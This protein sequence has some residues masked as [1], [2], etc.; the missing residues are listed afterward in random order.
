MTAYLLEVHVGSAV[1]HCS[2]T[3]FV[4][5]RGQAVHVE[6]DAE[7]EVEANV[8]AG[9]V[10]V[11]PREGT[12]AWM[13]D[14]RLH[15][16]RWTAWPEG[17]EIRVPGAPPIRYAVRTSTASTHT[18]NALTLCPRCRGALVPQ[19]WTA[20]GSYRAAGAHVRTCGV[21]KATIVA[22]DAVSGLA[23][24]EGPAR[25]GDAPVPGSGCETCG[26]GLRRLTLS[27]EPHTLVLEQ[28]PVCRLLVLDPGEREHLLALAEA[29]RP[30]GTARAQ[31]ATASP[32]AADELDDADEKVVAAMLTQPDT[33]SGFFWRLVGL[34]A[35]SRRRPP[36]RDPGNPDIP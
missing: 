31:R 15:E 16:Y 7:L 36:P 29:L 28:C 6:A 32:R 34:I 22:P 14:A 27:W 4:I 33:L 10:R 2:D 20:Q 5:G 21:C 1:T 35:P 8:A 13:G 26:V 3:V 30:L 23:V 9:I 12:T 11:R 18:L 19:N 24:L 17:A 25:R